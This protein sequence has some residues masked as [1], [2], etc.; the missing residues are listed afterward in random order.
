MYVT[1]A[2]G[3]LAL[4]PFFWH[5]S[6]ITTLTKEFL[7]YRSEPLH[8]GKLIHTRLFFLILLFPSVGQKVCLK[9]LVITNSVGKQPGTR[10]T[11]AAATSSCLHNFNCDHV[12][13]SSNHLSAPSPQPKLSHLAH[14]SYTTGNDTMLQR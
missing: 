7:K 5:I 9:H 13:A 2:L 11:E 4:F 8:K 14:L 3:L 10:G 1:F 12:V 6:L